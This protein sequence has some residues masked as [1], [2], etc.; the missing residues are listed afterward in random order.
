MTTRLL[1]PSTSSTSFSVQGL[2]EA[3]H[4][5]ILRN[6]MAPIIHSESM[7][8]TIQK[9]DKLELQETTDL[10]LGDVVVYRLDGLFVCHRIHGIEGHQLFLQ[11]D[12]ATGPYEAVSIR[13]VVGRVDC[14]FRD[15]KRLDVRRPRLSSLGMPDDSEWDAAAWMW[16]PRLAKA[17]IVAF[18]NWIA[19]IPGIKGIFR[20]ILR[21]L[22][23]IT[24]MERA[25]LQ[26]ID[27]YVTRDQ[28]HLD[29]LKQYLS[30]HTGSGILL[31]I[32]VGPA[33]FGIC[34]PGPW[35]MQIR[36]FLRPMTTALV[37]E[38]IESCHPV[39][40]SP[41]SIRRSTTATKN[42]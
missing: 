8:P 28:V 36:P 21:K 17:L 9:R 12:A 42:Q 41:H 19:G 40:S 29:Q 14:V 26:S 6:V 33:Y 10:K 18:M 11:G 13:Q 3:V 15:G 1:N 37:L 20:V 2:P 38:A 23:T 4:W 35:R 22:M 31:M 7:A 32:H 27:G 39:Q 16:N 30:P 25:A 24:V 34:T 5:L